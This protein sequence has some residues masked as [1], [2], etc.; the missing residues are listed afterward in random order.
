MLT[1]VFAVYVVCWY[2]TFGHRWS[3][4]KLFWSS[5]VIDVL[6]LFASAVGQ[7]IGHGLPLGVHCL[8]A[9]YG[10]ISPIFLAQCLV[11][12]FED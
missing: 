6:M 10:V 3:S 5:W 2:F 4:R 8:C 1:A 7:T 9:I 12:P 11:S